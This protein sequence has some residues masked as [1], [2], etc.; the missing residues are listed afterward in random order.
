MDWDGDVQLL[1]F[2]S[3]FAADIN[4]SLNA[5]EMMRDWN[6]IRAEGSR[7]RALFQSGHRFRVLVVA[8]RDQRDLGAACAAARARLESLSSFG[9]D[10]QSEPMGLAP[11][12]QR[13]G[14]IFVGTG[15]APGP[16]AM[17]F[18][19]QGS[20]YVG[21]LRELACR[22]PRMQAALAL[23]NDVRDQKDSLLSDRIYPPATYDGE[24]LAGSTRAWP[25][26][27]TAPHSRRSERS[28]W[29]CCVFSKIS[30]FAQT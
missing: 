14:A 1:A 7:S 23:A 28:A 20:Q 16:L 3:D 2:S 4:A 18:P 22:F 26:A 8:E 21:M 10:P 19:G 5:L 9:P 30:G 6:L 15:P 29:D 24:L 12:N 27:D 17:L 11:G 13:Q 25:S